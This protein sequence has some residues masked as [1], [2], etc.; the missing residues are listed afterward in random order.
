M[1]EIPAY[2]PAYVHSIADHVLR[3]LDRYYFRAEMIGFDEVPKRRKPDVPIIYAANHSGLAFSWEGMI[4]VAR[5]LRRAHKN[6]PDCVRPLIAPVLSKMRVTEPYFIEQFYHRAGGVDA[7]MSNFDALMEEG[8][9]NVLIFPEGVAGIDKGFQERYHLQRFSTSFIRMALKYDADIIPVYVI[10]GEFIHPYSYHSDFLNRLVHRIGIPFLPI[11]PL[12]AAALALPWSFYAGLPVKLIYVRGAPINVRELCG[13]NVEKLKPKEM[14]RLR[15][16]VQKR[17]QSELDE[18]VN[19]Y[20]K[21]PY[22]LV[23]LEQLW[24]QNLDKLLYILP[25]GWP[26]LFAEHERLFH[27]RGD[28]AMSYDNASHLAAMFRHPDVVRYHIPALGWPLLLAK[29]G[30][31][32]MGSPPDSR[33]SGA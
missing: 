12:V 24:A 23:E 17:M 18:Y 7:S 8:G 29:Y 10:N 27:K 31:K 30:I 5:M 16:V 20:G 22:H 26:L 21:D 6:L 14:H 19:E 25:T 1:G 4:F 13:E 9:T 15:D 32:D 33:K 28:G 2:N 3:F 11:G